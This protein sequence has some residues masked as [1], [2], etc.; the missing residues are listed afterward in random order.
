MKE[1]ELRYTVS[2]TNQ[3]LLVL[4][5]GL[6]SSIAC[7][8]STCSA[9]GACESKNSCTSSP[10]I[11]CSFSN[12][13]GIYADAAY[14]LNTSSPEALSSMLRGLCSPG[15]RT[16]TN[17]QTGEIECVPFFPFPDA[18]NREIM[19]PNGATAATRACGKWMETGNEWL[20]VYRRGSYDNDYW[21]EQISHAEDAATASSRTATSGMAKFRAECERTATAGPAALRAAAGRTYIHYDSNVEST[22]V[23]SNGFLRVLGYH[24]SHYCEGPVGVG[25][26]VGGTGYAIGMFSGWLFSADVLASSLHLFGEP[27]EMQTDAEEARRLIQA[28]FINGNAPNLTT[29][30]KVQVL[31]GA[32]GDEAYSFTE[33]STPFD[34]SLAGA[35]LKYY[36][37]DPS[38]A[39][40]YLKGLAAFCSYERYASFVT[41]DTDPYMYQT[42]TTLGGEVSRI[43]SSKPKADTLARLSANSSVDS[44]EA[45]DIDQ[46]TMITLASVTATHGGVGNP[47]VDCL[48]IMRVSFSDEVEEAR[49]SY[50]IPDSFYAKL[51]N[52]V[53]SVRIASGIAAMTSPLKETLTNAT[54]FTSI[55][56]DAGLRIVGA[57]RGSWAGKAR[58]VPR[59]DL[60]SDDGMFLMLM[61]Q[62]RAQFKS[63]ILDPAALGSSVSKCDH[64]TAW[65]QLT[66]NAYATRLDDTYC[67]VY[68]LGLAHRPLLD[69]HYDDPSVYARG[70]FVIAH[71]FAH[72]SQLSGLT[73]SNLYR[74]LLKHY[75]SDTHTEAYADV[76]AA[77]TVLSTGMVTRQDFD[78]HH[79]Q[80]WCSRQ[81]W[82]YFQPPGQV[83]P[84][85]NDRCNFLIQTL[86]EFFPAI[87]TTAA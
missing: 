26:Y 1:Q 47:S 40:S 9:K 20:E 50:A 71:E 62:S 4:A 32:S 82:W 70:L 81:P 61:K 16:Q 21:M 45:R 15:D 74:S 8:W 59:S 31:I 72:F 35:A 30:Q 11:F 23:D 43:K 6:I 53:L 51:Q 87:G 69:P 24:M 14:L 17:P 85:G 5:G 29:A 27:V 48:S 63:N 46:S 2:T 77:V 58:A 41:Y 79:C 49:F 52:M 60:S 86:D 3:F 34:T 33:S 73:N 36:N 22:A 78:I 66:W 68:F 54:L 64:N 28:D 56:A 25:A 10:D 75:Y 37:Q 84:I 12:K 65:S 39:L 42:Y 83:H 44:A 38:R 13:V 80:V 7:A 67:S 76:F 19:D 55:V 18:I 57:P